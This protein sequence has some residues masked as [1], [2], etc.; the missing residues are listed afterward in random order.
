MKQIENKTLK[1]EKVVEKVQYIKGK[2][3]FSKPKDWR[4]KTT[5]EENEWKIDTET[6]KY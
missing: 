4:I 3:G 1:R 5:L 2:T 6:D